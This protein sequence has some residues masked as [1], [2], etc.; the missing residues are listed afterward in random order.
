MEYQP[1]M[2][3]DS[4]LTAGKVSRASI[5]VQRPHTWPTWIWDLYE[6]ETS[7]LLMPGRAA[8]FTDK[9]PVLGRCGVE[10]RHRL[11]FRPS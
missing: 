9:L 10:V 1:W 4:G 3:R 7:A 6:D 11:E 8:G 5:P 2:R